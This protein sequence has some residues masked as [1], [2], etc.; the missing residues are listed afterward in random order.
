MDQRTPLCFFGHKLRLM[1]LERAKTRAR[2]GDWSEK[3]PAQRK[4]EIRD[5]EVLAAFWTLVPVT[6]RTVASLLVLFVH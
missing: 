4:G 3:H 2:T 1:N 6:L 5:G